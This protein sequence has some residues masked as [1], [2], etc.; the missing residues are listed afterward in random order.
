MA[1]RI[2]M[3][4][5]AAA[6]VAAF[7][8]S[9]SAAFGYGPT[10]G[11]GGGGKPGG[12]NTFTGNSSTC[13]D[14]GCQLT[15]QGEGFIVGE[16]VTIT[17]TIPGASF[18]ATAQAGEPQGSFTVTVT[19]LPGTPDG[20][21]HCS[22]TGQTS[23]VT[24]SFSVAVSPVLAGATGFRAPSAPSGS[25]GSG[26]VDVTVVAGAGAVIFALGGLLVLTSR[27]RSRRQAPTA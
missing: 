8:L 27:R 3:L 22:A 24:S 21:Y 9:A 13:A 5:A 11:G 20:A 17:C 14:T 23:G 7:T 16:A 2:T 4:A 18:P 19:V 6:V 12:A 15:F 26:G 10:G 1:R 25:G